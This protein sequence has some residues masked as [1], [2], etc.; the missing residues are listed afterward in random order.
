VVLVEFAIILPVL[1]L[2]I[3][4]ILYFGRYEDYSNQE[5]QLAEEGVRWA[6]VNNDPSTTGQTLQ[7]YIQN[8]AQP[9]L[10]NGSSDVTKAQ[11]YL[12]YPSG[13]SN[14]VGNP[15]TACVVTTVQ[16]PFFGLSSTSETV[17]QSATMRIE[18]TASNWTPA[19]NPTPTIPSACPS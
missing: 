19:N 5:T 2:L 15:V 10:A 6:A 14:V 17:A 8:Q 13:S 18:V 1:L 7:A 4:G 16:Y 12:Y 9:E 3:L 11:V